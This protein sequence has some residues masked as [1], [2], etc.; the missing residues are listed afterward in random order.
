MRKDKFYIFLV[1]FNLLACSFITGCKNEPHIS[2]TSKESTVT[3]KTVAPRMAYGINVDSLTVVK[4]KVKK[5]QFLSD[6]LLK[7]GVNYRTIDYIARHT[8]DSFDVRKMRRGHTYALILSNDS[9][10]KPLYFVY[11]DSPAHYF[12]YRLYDTINVKKGQ[13][14]VTVKPDV[15]VGEI[16]TSLW[17]SVNGNGYDVNLAM[18]LSEIYAW[19]IDFFELQPGD[20]YKVLY[21]KRYI[22]GKYVGL[23][24]VLAANF[25]HKGKNNYA[26]Y[27]IQNGKGA[28]FDKTGKS[29]ERTFLK[30]PLKY[31]RISSRFSNH[32]YHPILKI[33]RPHHGVDYAA[34]EGT[35]VHSLGD[36]VVIKMGFQRRGAGR[37][38][39]IRHNAMYTTQYAHLRAY[40]RGLHRGEKV[41]QGQLI[42]Y[43]GH[44]GLATGPHLDFRFFKSGVPVNPLKVHSP[45]AHPILKKFRPAFDSV[46]NK[47]IPELD[48]L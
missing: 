38:V 33:T 28:Y 27:F 13:K 16:K 39:K 8:K 1:V 19:T 3:A 20:G 4:G 12:R 26:F 23:G 6:I 36:G 42:G 30:A 22:D 14:H 47:Y 24:K 32:R 18:R 31:S 25:I 37:Y 9:V 5:N 15:A 34:P 2:N 44:T 43:V 29:L 40:A 35:P 17:N 11:E 41:R 45:P 10:K 46:V 48:S 21:N 7:Y